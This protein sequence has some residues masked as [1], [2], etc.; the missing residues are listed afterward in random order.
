MERWFDRSFDSL[1]QIFAFTERFFA[2]ECIDP[3]YLFTVNLAVEELFTNM[4]KY[5]AAGGGQIALHMQRLEDAVR[6]RLSDPESPPFDVTAPRPVDPDEPL[7]F[8]ESGGLGLFLVHKVVDSLDYTYRDGT[9]TI[10]FTR[11]LG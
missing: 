10:T 1:D 9:S 7:E 11:K 5:N 6:V 3:K 8:R 4:V 2:R